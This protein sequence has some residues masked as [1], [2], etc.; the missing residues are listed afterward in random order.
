MFHR[1]KILPEINQA[2]KDKGL[3]VTQLLQG[4]LMKSLIEED[5]AIHADLE[6]LVRLESVV[7]VMADLFLLEYQ[8]FHHAKGFS[9]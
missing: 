2:L 6:V 5:Q 3:V 4:N 1:L 7:F 9:D 8:R